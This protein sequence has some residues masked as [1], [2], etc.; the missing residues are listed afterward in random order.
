MDLDKVKLKNGDKIKIGSIT[1]E[2]LYVQ[3][4]ADPAPHQDPPFRKFLG[5]YLHDHKTKSLHPT[6][7]IK[8]YYDDTQE[9]F[10]IELRGKQI[11][12]EDIS[13]ESPSH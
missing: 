12:Q 2:V 9:I 7:F 13:L 10:L 11:K 3:G 4:E 8:Y 6:H 5:I 1:Y